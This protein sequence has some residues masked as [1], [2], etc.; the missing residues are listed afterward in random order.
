MLSVAYKAAI[1]LPFFAAVHSGHVHQLE[2]KH[3]TCVKRYVRKLN[4]VCTPAGEDWPCFHGSRMEDGEIQHL[5]GVDV[6]ADTCCA[7][8]C[9]T[10]EIRQHY[11]CHTESCTKK[12]YDDE[13]DEKTY[14]QPPPMTVKVSPRS[15][16]T[17]DEDVSSQKLER[18]RDHLAEHPKQR[19]NFENALR[20]T[21]GAPSSDNTASKHS[22]VVFSE[23]V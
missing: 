7:G 6:L 14:S 5:F 12:C 1:L 18:L 8:H 3:E 20:A 16:K 10:H 22:R 17:F 13:D 19:E 15:E 2:N 11:C 23:V 21:P 9:S 4:R